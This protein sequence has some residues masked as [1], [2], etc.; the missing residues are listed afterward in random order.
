MPGTKRTLPSSVR[1]P[2]FARLMLDMSHTFGQTDGA[3]LLHVAKT[4]LAVVIAAGVSMRI[5][6]ASP[7]T[8]MVTVVILMMHQHSGMVLARGFYRGVGMLVGNL[9]AIALIG[10]FP[11]ERVLFLTALVMWI[12]CCT[13]GAAYLRNYQSYGFVL[14]GYATCIAALPSID[15]PYDIIANFVTGLSEVSIGILSAGLVS[16]L[17]LPLHVRAMLM[18]TGQ[19][20]YADGMEFVRATLTQTLTPDERNRR[21]LR[22]IAARAQL[23]NLRSAAVFEDHDLR[24]R[25]D[26]MT[27]MAG[28]FLDAIA[29]VHALHQYLARLSYASDDRAA[30]LVRACCADAAQSLPAGTPGQPF[31][32]RSVESVADALDRAIA[33]LPADVTLAQTLTDVAAL[34]D[35]GTG[36]SLLRQ[37][38]VSLRAYLADFIALRQP[39]RDVAP[40]TPARPLKVSTTANRMVSAAAGLRA[41]VA[42]GAVSIFWIASGWSA[43]SGAVVS[44]TIASALYSIMPAPAAATRQ[45]ALGCAVAWIASLFFNFALLPGLD[46]FASLAVA[47]AL[48]IMVGS[49]LNTFPQT[50]AFGLGFNIYFCFLGNL[51]N[52]SIYAPEATFDAGFAAVLGIAAASLAYSVVAPYAGE[53]AARLYLRQ[54]RRLVAVDA[55][56]GELDGLIARFDAGVRDFVLQI[57]ARPATGHLGQRELLAWT[58]ASLEIGRSIAEMRT[59]TAGASVSPA[60]HA[61]ERAVCAAVSH[62]F[63]EADLDALGDAEQ[64]VADALALLDDPSAATPD[65]LRQLRNCVNF[66]RVSLQCNLISLPLESASPHETPA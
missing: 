46:G 11:Q 37:A 15:R 35:A 66:I 59:A 3:R 22:I 54:L 2:G 58:F 62:L 9:A 28:Q 21:Y 6:L 20:H 44:A 10:A 1:K 55:C 51:T 5:E 29:R 41:I 53:W 23:E 60:W 14:A 25:N 48:F 45:V 61:R 65:T 36:V 27:R 30:R 16:A 42:I 12:G 31:D 40:S 64:A 13:W 56:Y 8:A 63:K 52:P 39:S 33:R 43:A 49:Y 38:L 7:R 17:V 32:L 34:R 26:I 18:K 47:L 57:A 24:V 4:V 19:D 50:A